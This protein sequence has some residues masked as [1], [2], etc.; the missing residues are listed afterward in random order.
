MILIDLKGFHL[1]K[2]EAIKY[3]C[4]RL[5][6]D[7]SR[8]SKMHRYVL[9]WQG[10]HPSDVFA[11]GFVRDHP[12]IGNEITIDKFLE[13]DRSDLIELLSTTNYPEEDKIVTIKVNLRTGEVINEQ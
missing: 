8:L 2:I 7:T 11:W 9:I 6:L 12:S 5:E 3:H 13:L 4:E 1:S 10:Q